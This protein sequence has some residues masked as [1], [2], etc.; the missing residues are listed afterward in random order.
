[1]YTHPQTEPG[2]VDAVVTDIFIL[3]LDALVPFVPNFSA[4]VAAIL[5]G[6]AQVVNPAV[7]GPFAS[8][9]ANLSFGEKAA[10]FA[11][12]EGGQ[13]DPSLKPLAGALPQFTAFL[14]YSEAGV[15]DPVTGALTAIPLGWTLTGYRGPSDGHDEFKG[16]YQ[17]RRKVA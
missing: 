4:T 9:F 6:V 13:I 14:A 8:P 5:N 17:N 16:Y 1:M 3:T 11:L 15:L 10:V 2:G 12:L 7:T